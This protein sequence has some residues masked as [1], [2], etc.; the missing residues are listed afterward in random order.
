[1]IIVSTALKNTSKL[2][3]MLHLN[4]YYF[5]S[6]NPKRKQTG[7]TATKQFKNK[8]QT[9]DFQDYTIIRLDFGEFSST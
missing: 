7:K 6:N 1:M 9:K 5:L 4:K 2:K 3:M 8:Q